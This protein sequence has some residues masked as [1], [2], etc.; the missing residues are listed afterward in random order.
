VRAIR[1]ILLPVLV[2]AAALAVTW[3]VWEHERQVTRAQLRSQFDFSLRETVSRVEQRM[4]AY[5]QMLRGVQGLFAT[6]ME[7][8]RSAFHNY[9]EAL[10]L[11]AN[12][13]GIQAVGVVRHVPAARLEAHVSAMRR[14]GFPDYVI[15]PEGLRESYAPITQREP[16]IGRNR[17]R[18]GFD[19]WADPVR[20]RA[21]ETARDSG[22]AAVSGRVRLAVDTETYTR[23]GF[24]MYM[25]IYARGQPQDSVAMRRAGLVG[26]V[27]TS[28]H[29][30]E[31]MA[32]LYGENPPGLA[33]SLYDGVEPSDATLMYR[34]APGEQRRQ[35]AALAA[36]EYLV[37][38]GHTWT[39]ATNTMA[40]FEAR[41]ARDAAPLIAVTGTGLSLL[42][43]LLA[44][45]MATG[46]ARALR[47]AGAMT[48]ELRDSEEKFRAIANCTVNW[49]VWWGL[50]GKP[51]W[52]NPSVM[53]YT[54]YS[55]EECM[56]MPDFVGA[57]F[58]A[59]DIARVRA[60]IQKGLQGLGG[61][62]LEF[63][64]VRK[65]GSLFWLSMSWVPIHDGQ[66]VF[67]GFRTSGRD[68]TER[69][70][71]EVAREQLEA[72]LRESQKMEALGTLA[73]GVAHDFNNILT[74]ISGNVELARQDVGTDHAAQASL[75][76]IDKAS[77]RAK[78][79]VQQILAFGR[80]QQLERKATSLALIVL[81]SERLLRA[82]LP[83]NV[84]L[85]VDC[86]AD[87]PS[88]LA[89]ATQVK[90][91]IL[92][93]CANALHAVQDLARPG[94]IEVRL[95]AHDHTGSAAFP[96]LP[97]G[98]Y[99]CLTIRDNGSGMD[100]ATRAHIFEPF[101]TTKPMG[102][103]TGLGLSVVHG[104]AQAHEARVAVESAPG[105]GTTFRVYFPAID[106]PAAI[107][108][109]RSRAAQSVS[110][111]G[112]HVLYVDDEEAIIFLMTRLLGR[113]GY[114][115]SGYTD[116]HAAVAAA[117]A[118]PAQFDLAVTDYNM[119]G[120]SGLEVAMALREIRADLPVVLASGYITEELRQQAPAAG[121]R[122]L[123]YKPNTV[124]ELCEAV[125]RFANAQGGRESPLDTSLAMEAP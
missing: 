57:L 15:Q 87:A 4:A 47:L 67:S 106:A 96:D 27:Y 125:A 99:A 17:A 48:A 76:E 13:A 107:T 65:D 102:K 70:Q 115:V 32:S 12:L 37:F 120:M 66:G 62:D 60:E 8:D 69:K 68:I 95:S 90:Q 104:I 98:R 29:M 79:M 16:D 1:A 113:Q 42:L 39:L 18:L 10:Q 123:I 46:R 52:I 22:K 25:P 7:V 112:R 50:D 73:G 94:A 9:V 26:W 54:G 34:S 3:L 108:V 44:W 5:E 100:E 30:D 77:R 78:D 36:N 117:R 74:T 81:E 82:T 97:P 91:I 14:L 45:Q 101:F 92:N 84:V 59:E 86:L 64:C 24:V 121:V 93:L 21:M 111:E 72:Q 105:E 63:R 35:P 122:E 49:E 71:S 80:R 40:E 124:D 55:V 119:P 89:D 31:F 61:R 58:H 83:A 75:E 103:G 88:V 110:G 56:A 116:P 43:A 118:D 114:R 109:V 33:V 51:R 38:A 11:G 19:A 2:L 41:F 23:P 85:R 6:S 20:R 53:E 28:V